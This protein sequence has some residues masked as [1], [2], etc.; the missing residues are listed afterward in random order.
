MH[1]G[2]F[3]L[4]SHRTKIRVR[5]SY[6]RVCDDIDITATKRTGVGVH[7][8]RNRRVTL[9][10]RRE[11]DVTCIHV[12]FL[13]EVGV[14]HVVGY[15][16]VAIAAI[17]HIHRAYQD[18][19]TGIALRGTGPKVH[20]EVPGIIGLVQPQFLNVGM[21]QIASSPPLA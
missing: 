20:R 8:W 14:V 4:Q 16:H 12:G 13:Q 1:P 5:N 15:S 9:L 2:F 3:R 17:P 7:S 10:V 11:R 19:S 21:K 6:L 18:A